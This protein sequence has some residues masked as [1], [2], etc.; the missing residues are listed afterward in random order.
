VDCFF[1]FLAVASEEYGPCTGPEANSYHV[2]FMIKRERG[3]QDLL[4][5]W[6]EGLIKSFLA[7]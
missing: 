7:K 2:A 1:E 4:R 3:L 6:I 5:R